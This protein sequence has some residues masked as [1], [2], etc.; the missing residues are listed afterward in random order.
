MVTDLPVTT[1]IGVIS[2]SK[3]FQNFFETLITVLFITDKNM[4]KRNSTTVAKRGDKYP[5]RDCGFMIR[6]SWPNFGISRLPRPK[7]DISRLRR[8]RQG[9][10]D[11]R[12]RGKVSRGGRK[13]I[14]DS[15]KNSRGG[16]KN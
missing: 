4:E 12:D 3:T 16:K 1:F 14:R 2:R 10:H 6:Q 8:L 5:G 7:I 13:I 11:R 9:V 15:R